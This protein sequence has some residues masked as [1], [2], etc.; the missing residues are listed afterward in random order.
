M[1]A[2]RSLA[3]RWSL[4]LVALA[5]MISMTP[6]V[7]AAERI[8]RP[9]VERFQQDQRDLQRFYNIPLSL[10]RLA[11]LDRFLSGWGEDL[12]S[13]D[14]GALSR[15]DQID[16][17]MLSAK[18]RH[19]RTEL[20]EDHRRIRETTALAP[21]V[22]VIVG[23]E[24]RR[25]AMEDVDPREMAEVLERLATDASLAET[26]L[27]AS[28]SGDDRPEPT[29]ANRAASD[30][31]RLLRTLRH[32]FGYY[33]GYDPS[34]SWWCRA[35]MKEA[36]SAIGS[37]ERALRRDGAGLTG[38]ADDPLIGD[39]TGREALLSLL[40]REMIAYSPRELMEIAEREFAWCEA[41]YKK[42]AVEMGF[43]DDWRAAL[44]HV[45]TL[46]VPPG[47]QDEL[48]EMLAKEAIAFLDERDLV[49][50]PDLCRETWRIEMMSP[51][52]QRVA[53]FFLYGGQH[54]LVSYPTDEMSHAQKQMSMRA[55]NIHFSRAT[56][57]H[58]L[59]P[60]HHLQ[61]FYEDRHNTH[62]RL[63][64]TPFL[65]EGWALHWEMLLWDLG[66]PSTPED[67][68][69]MLFWRSH[70]CARILVSLGYHLE[71]MSTAEMIEVLVDRVGHERD[72]ATAE[73]RRY[74]GGNYGPLYQCAYLIG[75]LQLRALHKDLVGGGR[76][77]HR[78]FHDA[79]LR[80]GSMPI[81][82]IRAA[83]TDIPLHEG[84][85]AE[86]RF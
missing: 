14:F 34:F 52:R 78:E 41:E 72:S 1:R 85:K 47:E 3:A 25:V 56:V 23:L 66:F 15:A 43:G 11:R 84:F 77:T 53:P 70:R 64:G 27:K 57:Q 6:S 80:Q 61:G 5:L 79:V 54:I 9:M 49:T 74:V 21:F 28:L 17:T 36:E 29:V 19:A 46:H 48:I 62:R 13:I 24:Q 4:T 35:P 50:I 22:P 33:D 65:G 86:W 30:V 20:D 37:L 81:E 59:I 45:K 83:L 7:D 51:S 60:G 38:S 75:G 16:L 12:Q 18:V 69:G 2:R 39:P 82:M 73:V 10:D 42:A 63:F 8:V 76:M 40:E 71:E 67:R 44:E 26:R 68:M 58:E 55:N 31:G 32:W